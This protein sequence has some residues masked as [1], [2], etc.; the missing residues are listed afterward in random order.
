M[1]SVK[2]HSAFLGNKLHS[3]FEGTS[4][5]RN[6]F[7]R[8]IRQ[9]PKRDR[10]RC[11]ISAKH[12]NPVNQGFRFSHLCGQNVEFF[13]RNLILRNGSRLKCIKEPFSRSKVL[14][15]YLTPLWEEGLLLLRASVYAA[16][17]SGI[18]LLT[19]YGQNK[20]KGFI[21]AK[22]LPSV[23]SA[24]S[25]Y[26]QRDLEFGRVRRISP[27]SITLESCSFGPHKEEF[28]CG[29]A[30][31]VKLRLRPFASLRRG[32][33]VID[34]VLSHPSVL[35]V[36]KKDYTWLGIPPSEGGIQRHLS[37]EEG[38][39]HRT[40]I[41]R[42]AREEA[43]ARWA[44][45]RDEAA[46]EAA[47][48]GYFVS[49][50]CGLSKDDNL[51]ENATPPIEPANTKSF[52]C[53]KE[54]KHDHHCMDT[55]VDYDIKHA[56]LEKSFGVKFPG[57]G[58]RFWSRVIKRGRA[59]KF[60]RK[61]D[62]SDIC[63]SSIAIKKRIFE[64]SALAANE[65]FG[66]VHGKFGEASSPSE[67]YDFT[68]HNELLMKSEVDKNAQPVASGDENRSDGSQNG[69]EVRYPRT[70]S[71]SVH[72]NVND[73][74]DYVNSDHDLTSLT[75]ESKCDNL[76]TSGDAAKPVNVN[77]CTEEKEVLGLDVKDKQIVDNMPGVQSGWT[78]ENAV[79]VKPKLIMATYLQAPIRSLILKLG[80][81]SFFRNIEEFL[82]CILS[83]PI[84]NL[85]SDMGLKVEDIVAEHVDGVDV[86]QSVGITNMLPVTLDSVHFRGA[87]VMLLAYGDREV[88]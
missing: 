71:P 55:G 75:N 72:K 19:W 30:P 33:W 45:E 53:M 44:R 38:I 56:N 23:C 9:L 48:M 74:S 42:L 76:Q 26:I 57:S 87:T 32:K 7:H 22:L 2:G 77:S 29:E 20:A 73:L 88:R 35:V 13:R 24:I 36:Q 10:S 46:K 39:D 80:L 43:A 69:R 3:A 17:I 6:A 86:M 25:E 5:N 37:T 67:S 15:S 47:E 4:S 49:E 51:K 62:G 81:T 1:M 63:A 66:G 18:C 65:Y 59:H 8:E 50:C 40:K 85:K 78:S 27:L 11:G 82:S 52:F 70:W 83:G 41:R 14:L 28:S 58:L 61:A 31:T 84:Q 64:R 16:I 79:L 21:E 68:N 54:E 34:A 12:N 60:K